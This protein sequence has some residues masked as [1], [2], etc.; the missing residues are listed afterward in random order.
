[1][2]YGVFVWIIVVFA[3]LA[4]ALFIGRTTIDVQ[5]CVVKIERPLTMIAFILTVVFGLLKK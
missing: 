5:R 3:T 2:K 4:L 1:M